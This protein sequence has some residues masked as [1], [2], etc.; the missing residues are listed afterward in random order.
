MR[1][2]LA[3]GKRKIG[4][5]KPTGLL[6]VWN[7]IAP[8][9]AA[10]F[11]AWYETEHLDER[12]AVPGFRSA[13]RYRSVQEPYAYAAM[14]ELDSPAVLLTPAYLHLLANPTPRTRAIMPHFLDM[15]RAACRVPFDSAP[16]M[17]ALRHL[18]IVSLTQAPEPPVGV[19]DA[20]RVRLAIPDTAATGG[21]TPEQTLRGK[22]DTI[23]APFMLIEGEDQRAVDACIDHLTKQIH[24]PEARMLTLTSARGT[25]ATPL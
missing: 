11:D 16:Q 22:A 1:R 13:R 19:F 6:C 14:Y 10:E 23:P 17:G 4:P 24:A 8:E 5:M 7:R 21:V 25:G 18:A 9:H 3:V 2:S 12:M 20:V 15:H